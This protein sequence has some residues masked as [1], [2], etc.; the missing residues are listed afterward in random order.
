MNEKEQWIIDFIDKE[1][2]KCVDILNMK[3]VDSYIERFNPK[4]K[5]CMYGANKCKELSMLLGNMYKKGIL[6]RCTMGV[7]G[8][9]EGFPKWV[10]VYEL[11][12]GYRS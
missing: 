12:E 11:Y 1:P 5:V 4:H 10:Y 8:V 6:S 3:F 7:E 2:T 9:G